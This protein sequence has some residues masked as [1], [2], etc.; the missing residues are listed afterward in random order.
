MCAALLLLAPVASPAANAED[1]QAAARSRPRICLVLSGGGARGAAHV[2]VLKVLEELRVPVRLHRRHQHGRDRR[3]RPTPSGMG[4]RRDAGGDGARSP[5]ERL[6]NDKPPRAE[7]A[8]AQ[9][10]D[11]EPADY[12]G[13]ELGIARR[14]SRRCRKGVV[15]G[16]APGSRCCAELVA[17]PRHRRLRP[18]AD[19]VPRGGHR[20]RDRQDGGVRRGRP[21]PTSMRASM[22]VPGAMAPAEYGGRM[23]VDG[24]LTQQP[25]GRRGARDGRRRRSSR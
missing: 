6:F 23:L 5:V 21:V 9:Q 3:R 22:S 25:A 17:V 13:P 12:V 10:A 1:P 14:A 19:P 4:A 15:N 8:D 24:R 18:A 2:G 7:P 16:V 11:D 20:P